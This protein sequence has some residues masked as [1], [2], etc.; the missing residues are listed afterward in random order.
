[1]TRYRPAIVGALVVLALGL[2]L[3]Q[4]GAQPQT[5]LPSAGSTQ[6]TGPET[7]PCGFEVS[8]P[9]PGATS[10]QGGSAQPSV[11]LSP[12]QPAGGAPATV[13]QVSPGLTQPQLVALRTATEL[14]ADGKLG[15]IGQTLELTATLKLKADG[16]PVHAHTVRFRVD[17]APVGTDKTDGKGVAKVSYKVPNQLGAKKIEAEF[18]GNQICAAAKDDATL[19]TFK[20]ST[21]MTVALTNQA[22]IHEGSTLGVEGKIVR[23]SDQGGLDG[24]E[25]LASIG[26]KEIFK[27]GTD[28]S[29]GFRGSYKVP[30]GFGAKSSKVELRFEGDPLYVPMAAEVVFT[31][32]PPLKDA[33]LRWVGTGGKVGENAT[34]TATLSTTAV[35]LPGTGI[36]GKSIRFLY[37]KD[38]QEDATSGGT[39]GAGV[40]NSQGVASVQ[41]KI[42]MVKGRY[43]LKAYV[44]GVQGE[45]DVQKLTDSSS[46]RVEKAPV[47]LT[48]S[49]PGSANAKIGDTITLTLKVLR[50][51]DAA[52]VRR[53]GVDF[54]GSKR[55]DDAGTVS[56][57][58]QIGPGPTGP[59]QIQIPAR[60]A[61]GT[62]T[63]EGSTSKT[64]TIQVGPKTN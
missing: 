57:T 19:G 61:A 16:K 24:R 27:A 35:G 3:S 51:T 39:L 8:T 13:R 34:V 56:A 12:G 14:K 55:T 11:G 45:L 1:M 30:A 18:A 60:A 31:V 58:L 20:A 33:F 5:P 46:L 47:T 41:F 29:G 7:P 62:Y 44:E 9:P 42:D 21:K 2:A 59:R 63:L 37:D 48:V 50:A 32:L 6:P 36:A 25:I 26:G 54:L 40:T 22:P 53:V 4:V 23:T 10:A 17:G 28:P 43:P 52:P 49:G 64:I 15:V 38:F